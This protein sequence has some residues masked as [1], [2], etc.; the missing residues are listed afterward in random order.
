MPA[1][2]VH[3]ESALLPPFTIGGGGGGGEGGAGL[4]RVL[5]PA[6]TVT[7]DGQQ[8]YHTAPYGE[9]GRSWFP[10]LAIGLVLVLVLVVW[11]VRRRA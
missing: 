4:L 1:L 5:K 2:E 7:V 3:V 11:L 6:V 10:F 9:P 8:L